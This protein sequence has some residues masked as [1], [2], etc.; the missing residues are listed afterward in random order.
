MLSIILTYIKT[1]NYILYK[2]FLHIK[3]IKNYIYTYK[4]LII[5]FKMY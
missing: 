3:N 4:N 2:H 5:C 1:I